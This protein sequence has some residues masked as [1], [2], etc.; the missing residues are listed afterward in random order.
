M[1]TA[2]RARSL[3]PF[4]EYVELET[5]NLVNSS[6]SAVAPDGALLEYET[7]ELR[8]HPTNVV[9]DNETR[10]DS[11]LITVDSANRPG[12]LVEVGPKCEHGITM[13]LLSDF[14]VFFF[15]VHV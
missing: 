4:R 14:G 6:L 5:A 8:V 12:T 7:L 10:E 11:T 3:K 13:T 1:A 2:H 15:R 9:I